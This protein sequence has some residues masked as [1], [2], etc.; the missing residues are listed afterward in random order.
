MPFTPDLESAASMV[1]YSVRVVLLAAFGA[2]PPSLLFSPPRLLHVR[3]LPTYT[4]TMN[5]VLIGY[6]G[7]GKST[8]AKRLANK[9]WID[10][11]DTDKLITDAA[12]MTIRKI[13][14]T[15]GEAGFRRREVDAVAQAAA[16]DNVVIAV[17]GG[18]VMDPQNVSALKKNGKIIWL[19]ANPEVLH[20]RIRNDVE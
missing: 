6:R 17:G 19:E 2:A 16:R 15:E 7:S 1:S 9:L 13:F 18:A 20:E 10:F 14:E 12:G 5:I 4:L 3:P 8:V 11:V